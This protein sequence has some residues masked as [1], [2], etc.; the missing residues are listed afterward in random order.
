[1]DG[2]TI[3]VRI[4]GVVYPV[5]YI[6]VDSP[7]PGLDYSYEATQK[8]REL[9]EG[10]TVT[11]VRDFSETDQF[12]RLL[13][14]VIVGE[15]FVNN[16]LVLSGVAQS[17]AYPPDT[18]CQ[19]TFDEAQRTARSSKRGMWAP[20]PTPVPAPTRAPTAIS[21]IVPAPIPGGNCSPSYPSVCI[22][23]PPPDLDC[24]DISYRRFTVMGSDPHN[25]DG[26]HDG[27]GCES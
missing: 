18:A 22:P 15:V 6:G 11:L 25:F 10:K 21:P 13:R 1:M 20:T 7:E 5:R 8:N 16:E 2:D 26:D 3:R 23:P 4:E 12:D 17:K 27:I 9:V 19:A 24:G 14:Y